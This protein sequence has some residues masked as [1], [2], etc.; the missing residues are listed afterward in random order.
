MLHIAKEH[1]KTT[2][3]HARFMLIIIN[4]LM[5]LLLVKKFFL[6]VPIASKSLSRR[7]YTNVIG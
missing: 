3:D 2:Q 5:H 1:F 4:V 7:K 6:C